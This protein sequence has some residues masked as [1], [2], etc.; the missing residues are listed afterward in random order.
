M[1]LVKKDAIALDT[2]FYLSSDCM[3]VLDREGYVLSMNPAFKHLLGICGEGVLPDLFYEFIYEEDLRYMTAALG[4][5]LKEGY[6]EKDLECRILDQS[7]KVVWLRLSSVFHSD[8]MVFISAQDITAFKNRLFELSDDKS[9]LLE[10]IELVPHPI[11]LK[12]KDGKYVLLNAA[13]ADLFG[14]NRSVFLGKDDSNFIHDEESLALVKESDEQ[15]LIHGKKVILEDQVL[16]HGDGLATVLHTIKIPFRNSFD[17]EIYI[18]G[19]SIDLTEIKE[20]ETELRKANFELDNFVYKA[21]HDLRAPLCSITGLLNLIGKESDEEMRKECIVQAKKS[22]LRLD[23]Y[24]SDLTN[25]T[26][27]S[28]LEVSSKH[29]DFVSIID[30][31]FDHLKYMEKADLM[32][33]QVQVDPDVDLTSDKGR[34]KIIFMNLISNA[35]KYQRIDVHPYLKIHVYNEAQDVC[36]LIKDN[37]MGIKSKYISRVYDMFFRASEKSFG[38][39]LGLYIVKQIVEK[40]CASIQM[41]SVE[42]E[43]TSFLIQIPNKV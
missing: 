13:Q 17:G 40:L 34:I 38:S 36:I 39:G 29:I 19:V 27:N 43:G 10:L 3:C 18:L 25:L 5:C 4:N 23:N 6:D 9:K 31:C 33:F 30:H 15:V 28:R 1:T 26:R 22:V 12:N 11:F 2:F 8:G 32:D 24:I 16:N 21:S 35:I 41:E 37:G 20:V 14:L 42:G 7:K